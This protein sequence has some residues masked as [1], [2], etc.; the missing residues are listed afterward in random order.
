MNSIGVWEFI[1]IFTMAILFL[2]VKQIAI[3]WQKWLK[4][5]QVIHHW[6]Y[7]LESELDFLAVQPSPPKDTSTP[8]SPKNMRKKIQEELKKLSPDQ[9]AVYSEA[10]CNRILELEQWRQSLTIAAFFPM[11]WEPNLKPLLEQA[12]I[13]K[14]SLYLPR[15][16]QANCM[17]MCAVKNLES[18]L[19]LG[20]F[21]ILTPAE[22]CEVAPA[23]T[24]W[25][26]VLV[27]GTV[28]GVNGERIG[29]GG[30]FYDRWLASAQVLCKCAAAF[31]VQVQQN[32]LI[33]EPHDVPMDIVVTEQRIYK[34]KKD[35]E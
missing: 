18:D 25:D 8:F 17:E 13:Q 1:L 23:T 29:K 35:E 3:L 4:L 32:L 21:G 24:Q 11:K 19:Q 10:L 16:T 14:K 9:R 12:I 34:R 5:K 31:E 22:N 20:T 33:Q 26:L 28:F 27:P 15:I 2:D 30:G 7:R 6:T